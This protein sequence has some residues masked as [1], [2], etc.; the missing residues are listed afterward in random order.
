VN[1]LLGGPLARAAL[2]GVDDKDYHVPFKLTA[3]LNKLTIKID[4]PKLSPADIKRLEQD[5]Q[6]NNRAS[7]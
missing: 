7:E 1:D 6:R 4:R 3:K 5:G 2:T